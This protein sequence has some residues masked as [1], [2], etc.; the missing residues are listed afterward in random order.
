M[1]IAMG[2]HDYYHVAGLNLEGAEIVQD[3]LRLTQAPMS[4]RSSK[5]NDALYS[6]SRAPQARTRRSHGIW[7]TSSLPS[8]TDH[9]TNIRRMGIQKES[10]PYWSG[11]TLLTF[12]PVQEPSQS[13]SSDSAIASNLW[14][15][16]QYKSLEAS[17]AQQ[18]HP[19]IDIVSSCGFDSIP[20]K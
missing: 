8:A 7:S 12:N 6:R 3:S 15:P 16:T 1:P 17:A 11:E 4:A 18:L 14:T 2:V 10:A 13:T 9:I 5:E 19:T 20:A